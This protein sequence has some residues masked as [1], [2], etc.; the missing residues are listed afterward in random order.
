[1][2]FVSLARSV[3]PMVHSGCLNARALL[4]LVSPS[5]CVGPAKGGIDVINH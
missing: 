5:S 4:V 3:T 2:L 1:M